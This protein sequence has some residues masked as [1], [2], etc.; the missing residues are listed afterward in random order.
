MSPPWLPPRLQANFVKSNTSLADL[1]AN[2][3]AAM[4]GGSASGGPGMGGNT[5]SGNGDTGDNDMDTDNDDGN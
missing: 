1:T 4:N 2:M 5:G 3:G